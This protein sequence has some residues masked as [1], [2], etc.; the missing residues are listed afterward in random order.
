MQGS[1]IHFYHNLLK[2]MPKHNDLSFTCRAQFTL[3]TNLYLY[4]NK[5]IL[6]Y[7][8]LSVHD[9]YNI[10]HFILVLATFFLFMTPTFSLILIHTSNLLFHG[11]YPFSLTLLCFILFYPLFSLFL[12]FK[13]IVDVAKA[14]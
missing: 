10:F 4:S 12:I 6:F 1:K 2:H 13:M 8:I 7:R 3:A 9:F 5:S 14:T 11:L